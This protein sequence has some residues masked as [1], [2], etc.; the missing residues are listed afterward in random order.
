MKGLGIELCEEKEI[1][2]GTSVQILVAEYSSVFDGSLGVFR[3]VTAKITLRDNAKPKF[4]KP[5]AVIRDSV[6]G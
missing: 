1:N 4:F 5:R 3:G 6:Q 2:G